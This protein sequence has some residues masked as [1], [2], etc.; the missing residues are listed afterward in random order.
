MNEAQPKPPAQQFAALDLGSNSFHMV[1]AQ[2]GDHGQLTVVD[3][4]KESVRLA[5]GL[6]EDGGLSESAE[7]RAIQCLSVFGER[8]RGF[9]DGHVRAV[10]T[11]TLRKAK[12]VVS[13]LEKASAA[14]GHP[15]D[16][17]SGREEARLI[18]RGV[19]RDVESPGCLLVIDIGGGSTELIIGEGPDTTQLDSCLLY[20]SPSPRDRG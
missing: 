13:F 11:N 10:G 18:Y 8:V 12:D 6:D 9:P 2:E 4:L 3:R 14:L 7:A 5:A 19:V 15:I 20:T 17:I 1:V 16:V